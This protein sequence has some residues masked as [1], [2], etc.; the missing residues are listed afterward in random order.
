MEWTIRTPTWKTNRSENSR[1]LQVQIPE[2]II[3]QPQIVRCFAPKPYGGY[4]FNKPNFG[5]VVAVVVVSI[6]YISNIWC[7]QAYAVLQMQI[8]QRTHFLELCSRFITCFTSVDILS[9]EFSWIRCYLRRFFFRLFIA[10]HKFKHGKDLSGI[11]IGPVRCMWVGIW[12]LAICSFFLS[13][14]GLCSFE[15]LGRIKN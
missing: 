4:Q 10:P 1:L 11:V 8:G 6:K 5:V 2:L 12:F 14:F 9:V 3:T 7:R 15:F 13:F